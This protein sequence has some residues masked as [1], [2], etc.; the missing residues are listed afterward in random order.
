MFD[1]GTTYK[2]RTIA[3]VKAGAEVAESIS[4]YP[5]VVAYDALS[6]GPPSPPA[7]VSIVLVA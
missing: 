5:G 2:W 4:N 3:W 7:I 1:A 6:G